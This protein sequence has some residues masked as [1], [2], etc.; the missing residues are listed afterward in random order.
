MTEKRRPGV[1]ITQ[2]S[3]LYPSNDRKLSREELGP[4]LPKPLPRRRRSP[5]PPRRVF[6][7]CRVDGDSIADQ[8]A[9]IN[10][11]AHARGLS[12]TRILKEAKSG[13]GWKAET[14]DE[15]HALLADIREGDLVLVDKLARWSRDPDFM[16]ETVREIIQAKA[17]IH[18]IS[19]DI[20]PATARG[21]EELSLRIAFA[22]RAHAHFRQR[23]N[24]GRERLRDAGYRAEG[25]PSFGYRRGEGATLVV[26]EEKAAI[27]ARAFAMCISGSSVIEISR[28]LGLGRSIVSKI[29]H[30]RIYIGELRDSDGK[31]I[32][33]KHDPIVDPDVFATAA[34]A[35]EARRCA[36]PR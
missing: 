26:V 9:T 23:T 28:A 16:Y 6:G 25:L 12:P 11:A 33:A 27:V 24:R 32:R 18:F 31:W 1:R 8:E 35:I 3:S 19:E 4:W 7:Y 21:A 34:A 10:A 5:F 22:R 30:N 13:V 36:K 14:R 15:I 20:D 2:A 29:L 17:D